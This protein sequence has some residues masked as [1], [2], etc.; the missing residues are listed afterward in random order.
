MLNNCD[1]SI[2][3]NN[4]DYFCHNGAALTQPLGDLR[5]L[6]APTQVVCYVLQGRMEEAAQMLM[7]QASQQ[8]AARAAYKL[9][10]SLLTKMPVYS[11][12]CQKP[13]RAILVAIPEPPIPVT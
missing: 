3:Q 6:S 9:M 2:D 5:L 1:L 8:P 4:H 13:R 11:V 7:K 12:R 10:D